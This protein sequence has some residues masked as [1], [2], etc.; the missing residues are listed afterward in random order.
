MIQ[1]IVKNGVP[2]RKFQ[3]NIH[4]PCD[5]FSPPVSQC[6]SL[7]APHQ[8]GCVDQPRVA[9]CL[10]LPHRVAFVFC[11]YLAVYFHIPGRRELTLHL[12]F[13]FRLASLSTIPSSSIH[14][15]LGKEQDLYF[16]LK[17]SPPFF[18]I[19]ME[20]LSHVL[21]TTA[22]KQSNQDSDHFSKTQ[23]LPPHTQQMTH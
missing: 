21:T 15:K 1:N 16:S 17:T 4:A 19:T 5:L 3:Q 23:S 9:F 6:P 2:W 7:L 11:C 13:S 20:I 12:S 10:L 18:M 22:Q 8:L 14:G